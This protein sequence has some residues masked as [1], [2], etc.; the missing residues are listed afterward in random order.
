MRLRYGIS[1]KTDRLRRWILVSVAVLVAAGVIS[2]TAF[3]NSAAESQPKKNPTAGCLRRGPLACDVMPFEEIEAGACV[4]LRNCLEG[5]KFGDQTVEQVVMCAAPVVSAASR[6]GPV[7]AVA[8]ELAVDGPPSHAAYLF[9]KFPG[10]WCPVDQL[11]EPAWNHGGY[12][13]TRFQFKWEAGS[14]AD[15]AT[16]SVR[17]ERICHRPLDQAEIAAGESDIAM[18]ECRQARY[19]AGKK[20]LQKLSESSS[21]GPCPAR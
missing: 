3:A 6:F 10:G 9:A 12:C 16:L 19:R 4:G 15:E 2:E 17:S 21:E 13:E 7:A 11:L 5:R 18:S 1:G 14:T 8:T 20:E